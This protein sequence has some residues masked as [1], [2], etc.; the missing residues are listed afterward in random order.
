MDVEMPNCDGLEATRRIK[1]ELPGVRVVMLTVAA[2]EDTLLEALKCGADGYLLKDLESRQFFELLCGVM[3]E[4]NV[5]SPTLAS[6][7][8]KE[9]TEDGAFEE[10]DTSQLTSRQREVLELVAQGMTNREVAQRLFISPDTVK[11]HVSQILE[12]LQVQ[13]RYELAQFCDTETPRGG[14]AEGGE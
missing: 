10:P 3:R 14:D 8:L 9:L 4:E 12:R 6:R 13:S 1:A 11:Y 2:D 7:V 5:L